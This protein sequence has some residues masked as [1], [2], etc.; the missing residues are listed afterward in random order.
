MSLVIEYQ[1]CCLEVK[2]SL[3]AQQEDLQ[4]LAC[5]DML[6]H[7]FDTF[8]ALGRRAQ[9]ALLLGVLSCSECRQ[10]LSYPLPAVSWY[11][12]QG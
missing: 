9:A 4:G 7:V 10:W 6:S 3:T 12:E 1:M 8:V 2:Y 5:M 11:N